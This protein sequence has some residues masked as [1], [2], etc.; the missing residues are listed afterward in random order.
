MNAIRTFAEVKDHEVR[1]TLPDSVTSK[2]VEVIIIPLEWEDESEP[3]SQKVSD[4][5]SALLDAPDMTDAEYELILEK[6]K[7]LNLWS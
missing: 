2:K 7:A 5:Q 6:R 3:T 4:L 1:V